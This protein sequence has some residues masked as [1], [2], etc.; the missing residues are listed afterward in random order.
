MK[1]MLVMGTRPEAIK[2]API[3]EA[4][5]RFRKRFELRVCVTA[6]H[7]QMLDQ[8]S[9][10]FGIS[11][12][13]DL[14]IMSGNQDLF[15]I[16]ARALTGLK[17]VLIKGKPD[18]VLV[19]GDTTTT[20]AG[21]LAAFYLGIPVGH[22]EAGLR[23]YDK[24]QPFPEEINRRLTSVITDYHFAPTPWAAKKSG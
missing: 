11:P 9:D 13:Y 2:L 15:E 17:S 14:N 18:L 1:I 5:R 19:Q 6:Q 24:A 20:M 12:D 8:V 10:L 4:L 21:A 7:R 3:I 16:T 23:T 22:V